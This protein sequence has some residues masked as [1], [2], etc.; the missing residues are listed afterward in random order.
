MKYIF[1]ILF[2]IVGCAVF[3][4]DEKP[5]EQVNEVEPGCVI[6]PLEL[7]PVPVVFDADAYYRSQV[8]QPYSLTYRLPCGNSDFDLDAYIL[9][10][11]PLPLNEDL[12]FVHTLNGA[13]FPSTT[14]A[15]LC[16]KQNLY[17]VL[18]K[19]PRQQKA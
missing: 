17:Y 19:K 16:G 14:F 11:G 15:L 3:A 5:I 1:S 8:V 6:W 2:L 12:P 13:V 9:S 4:Q 7:K 10:Q 18:F